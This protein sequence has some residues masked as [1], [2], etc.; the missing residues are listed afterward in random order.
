MRMDQRSLVGLLFFLGAAQFLTVMMVGEALYPGYSVNANA[1]SDLGVGSTAPLFNVSVILVGA[2]GLAAAYL[3]HGS[4]GRRLFTLLVLLSGVGAILV[5]LFPEDTGVPHLVGA[6][7]AFLFGG[8]AAIAAY[9][10]EDPPLR[11]VS[12]ALGVL[13]LA[14]LVLFEAK[15]FGGIGFG[16][17]ERMIVYPVLLWEVVFGG[18]LMV[19]TRAAQ[20]TDAADRSLG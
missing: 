15:A 19:A 12:V 1:I 8:L 6:L 2:L 7:L 11:Y 5:G 14:S 18:S 3:F 10:L 9:P 17:M 20:G 4:H 13:G 16:G